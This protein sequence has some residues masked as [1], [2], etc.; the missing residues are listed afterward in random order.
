[1]PIWSYTTQLPPDYSE[2]LRVS[3]IGAAAIK[4]V[5]GRN[6]LLFSF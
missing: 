5:Y 1:M 6:I 3:Q 2:L 4:A